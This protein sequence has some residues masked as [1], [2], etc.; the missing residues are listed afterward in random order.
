MTT[1]SS[2][3]YAK[4][5]DNNPR[6]ALCLQHVDDRQHITL[7]GKYRSDGF[8]ERRTKH[9]CLGCATAIKAEVQYLDSSTDVHKGRRHE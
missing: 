7:K 1:P 6:C 8:L 2:T 4:L 5:N 9:V 3:L